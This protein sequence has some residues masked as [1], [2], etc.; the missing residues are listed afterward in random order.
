MPEFSNLQLRIGIPLIRGL[1]CAGYSVPAAFVQISKL[2]MSLVLRALSNKCELCKCLAQQDFLAHV[3][4]E[5]NFREIRISNLAT[6]ADR[7]ESLVFCITR[8]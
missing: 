3:P 2:E 7:D 8:K 5:V 4:G 6:I 1:E